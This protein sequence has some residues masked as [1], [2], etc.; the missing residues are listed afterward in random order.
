MT[1][2]FLR[3]TETRGASFDATPEPEFPGVTPDASP[4][5]A[6]LLSLDSP[7][8]QRTAAP[9]PSM[10]SVPFFSAD[11]SA[12]IEPL[13]S[14]EPLAAVAEL[15]AHASTKGPLTIGLFG[16]AGAGKT[17]ALDRL[18]AG[19]EALADGARKLGGSSPFVSR[20][21]IVRIDATRCEGE[22]ATAIANEIHHALTSGGTGQAYAALAT[23]AAHAVRD[24]ALVARELNEKLADA[25][26]RL[27]V[28]RRALQEFDGRRAKLAETILYETAGSRVD[29]YARSN[30]GRL[31]GRLRAFGFT[32]DPV[33][34]YKDLVR[35]LAERPAASGRIGAFLHALWGFKG[36]SR[37]IVFAVLFLLLAWVFALT[38]TNG[39]AW[40]DWLNV[41]GGEKMTP[42]TA[43]FS[44]NL[45]A[46]G[47]LR[48]L[49]ILAALACLALNVWR[50]ARFTMPV[51]RG[52]ALL[53]A[54]QEARSRDIAGLL[55]LQ[56]RRVE[57]ISGEA[58]AL[59]RLAE[60]AER[61]AAASGTN[62]V[63][64]EMPFSEPTSDV[65]TRVAQ[66]FTRALDRAM[67]AG[68]SQT[69][70][71]PQRIL[72]ALDSLDDVPAARRLDLV[73]AARRLLASPGFVTVL[74]A[75]LEA[76]ESAGIRVD[77]T[78]QIPVRIEGSQADAG[79]WLL[80][81]IDAPK[82]AAPIALDVTRSRLDEPLDPKESAM[83]ATLAPLAGNSPRAIKRF[84]NLYRLARISGE[85]RPA[86]ALMLAMTVG[87]TSAERAGLKQALN[88]PGPTL[89]AGP[90][91]ERLAWALS[92][93]TAQGGPAVD[94]RSA[95]AAQAV[96]ESYSLNV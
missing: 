94:M 86:L 59:A 16:K 64:A 90:N 72:V 88:N 11:S 22:P 57:T 84:A 89:A 82:A 68:A 58:D 36:Q 13:R 15:A 38:E 54:D 42:I 6:P 12:T 77:K 66:D 34:N 28:E 51:L 40:L 37:L 63:R 7:E 50:A 76:L 83:L 91:D 46:I 65:G 26:L 92:A 29:A 73:E 44:G 21:A 53:R 32:G 67:T 43:W 96:A 80:D 71:A 3:N 31:E 87:G 30:R 24:P 74:A 60:T 75:D 17:T 62:T 85:D 55:A 35:D 95:R 23:E 10:A 41:N 45:G 18:C 61:R 39:P 81:L 20:L 19:I 27:D 25:R 78:V 1:D 2:F 4:S 5:A 47:S 70:P 9:T 56:T 52:V 14:G 49:S 93:I 69:I 48:M 79:Q 33:A 8:V